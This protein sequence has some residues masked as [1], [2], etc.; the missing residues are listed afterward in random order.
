MARRLRSAAKEERKHLYTALYDELYRR[1]PLHPQLTQ[2]ADAQS[3][4]QAV[5]TQMRLL[6]RYLHPDSIFLEIG[7][8][9]CSLSREVSRRV[10]K[11]YAVDVSEEI[12]K[13]ESFPQ[14]FEL[15]ISDGSSIPVPRGSATLAYS[16]RLME[17]LHP[18]DAVDQL[19][20]VYVALAEGGKYICITP[21]SLSGPY[22]ISRYFDEV[23]TGFHLKEYTFTELDELFRKV[24]FSRIDAY[25]GGQG[26]YV[27]IPPSVILRC[28]RILRRLPPSL[29]RT[30]ASTLPLRALLGITM[31]GTK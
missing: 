6:G 23:A 24:G 3:R 29:R 26:T 27:R 20:N 9:D 16:R 28:E 5:S 21:N 11:A 18:D 2:K 1:V 4:L 30:I 15:I 8:G 14:N 19:K 13:G 31:V 12:T 17:H 7:A 22:D 10:R 25:A